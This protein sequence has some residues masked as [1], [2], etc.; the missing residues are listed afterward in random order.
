MSRENLLQ[1]FPPGLTQTGLYSHRRLLE[2]L[3]F[4]FRKYRDYNI[5]VAKT[6][7]LISC[8]VAAQLICAIVFAYN[9][10][11]KAGFLMIWC[12]SFH[13]HT[14]VVCFMLFKLKNL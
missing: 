3:T 4:G 14:D 8:T 6:K 12:I 10:L 7:G 9:Y 13:T 5:Y 1:G 2:A 11:Q